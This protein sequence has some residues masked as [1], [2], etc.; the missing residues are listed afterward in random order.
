MFFLVLTYTMSFKKETSA[1]IV[2]NDRGSDRTSKITKEKPVSITNKSGPQSQNSEYVANAH[3][4]KSSTSDRERER[5]GL[6]SMCKTSHTQRNCRL[7][8]FAMIIHAFIR[9]WQNLNY[10]QT[11][12]R[13]DEFISSF[14]LF[15]ISSK[16]EFENRSTPE[17]LSKN[18]HHHLRD[19]HWKK[20]PRATVVI[21][22]PFVEIPLFL[23]L[24]LTNS[25][26]KQFK[27]ENKITFNTSPQNSTFSLFPIPI[28][29]S[30][31]QQQL[32][33]FRSCATVKW[34]HWRASVSAAVE[35]N[36]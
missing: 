25:H 28:F 9:N 4:S 3:K 8:Y 10:K 31:Q 35:L 18:T 21:A 17:N 30:S 33:A 16:R 13:T 24:K 36:S 12:N 15:I 11:S 7:H 27:R 23:Y 32:A 34:N 22:T 2:L 5:E 14:C 20:N 29:F 1:V 19:H 6:G 26:E